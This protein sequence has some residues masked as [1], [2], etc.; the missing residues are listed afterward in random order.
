MPT[1]ILF[2]LIS[3][4]FPR[5]LTLCKDTIQ[6]RNRKSSGKSKKKSKK[7]STS[8]SSTA[9]SPSTPLVGSGHMASVISLPGQTSPGIDSTYV[10]SPYGR[11]YSLPTPTGAYSPYET[12][13]SAVGYGPE[14][15]SYFG[16]SPTAYGY[17]PCSYTSSE[18]VKPVI[19]VT[20]SAFSVA[21]TSCYSPE[22]GMEQVQ[23]QG[24]AVVD[25]RFHSSPYSAFSPF[26]SE[27]NSPIQPTTP[28]THS[29]LV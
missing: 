8:S 5:P 17:T 16:Y 18:D 21:P 20:S 24:Q 23:V 29:P 6:T 9:S 15:S 28:Q 26:A 3:L 19:Q 12:Q 10:S 1:L 27:H 4:Q 25:N 11:S 13:R 22:G 14:T 7:S 2:I